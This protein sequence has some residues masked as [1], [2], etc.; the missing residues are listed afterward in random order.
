MSDRTLYRWAAAALV[1]SAI[2][3][4]AGRILHPSSD[5]AGLSST[6]WGPS[7]ISWLVGLLTGMIGVTGLYLRQR[8]E[9][10]RLGFVGAAAAWVG[11]GLLSGAMY[12]EAIIEP[13]LLRLSPDLAESLALLSGEEIRSFLV[14]FFVA[15]GLFG[16]GFLLFGIAMYKAAVMPRRAVVLFVAGSVVGGPQGFLPVAVATLAFLT[17]GVGLAALG[18]ALWS[19]VEAS[20]PRP[21]AMRRAAEGS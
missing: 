18:V 21:R 19:G 16:G 9:V 4:T 10:G 15:V 17:M 6:L 2:T 14:T 1:V 12:F 8:I 20:E 7:H 5:A 11:M 13:G 3:V